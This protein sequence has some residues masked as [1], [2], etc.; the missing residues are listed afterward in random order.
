MATFDLLPQSEEDALHKSRLLGVEERPFKRITKR[1][2]GPN[3]LLAIPSKPL[4]P[5][6]DGDDSSKDDDEAS[7]RQKLHDDI[8]LDFAAFDSSVA[9]LQFLRNGNEAERERY[10]VDKARILTTA[11]EVRDNTA[12]LRLQLEEAKKTLAQRKTF[13]VL[14]E[15]I[16]GNMMLRPRKDQEAN[17]KKLEDECR[18]LER[19]SQTYAETWAER[20]EQFGRIVEEGLLLRRLIRDEK[21]EVERR[22]GMEEED[23]E[24]DGGPGIRTPK[25]SSGCM[26]PRGERA[27]S[28]A[29]D[30]GLKPRPAQI[31]A[32]S[33]GTS[34]GPWSRTASPAMSERKSMGDVESARD[35]DA[36]DTPMAEAPTPVVNIEEPVVGS[37][38]DEEGSADKMD[39][40]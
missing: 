2:L 3:T 30:S 34:R 23:G 6:P 32:L 28:P 9:R 15:K 4:T 14:A 18:E 19:E 40:T 38:A 5:P 22:E 20:R 35:A 13:D 24:V 26:T 21:E 11:Q 17:L 39:T 31:G 37:A 36:A 7:G 12:L 33:R 25:G 27:A 8:E 29:T 10:S 1:L 16:T